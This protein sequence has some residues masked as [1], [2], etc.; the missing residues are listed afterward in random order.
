MRIYSQGLQFEIRGM[1][2][3]LAKLSGQSVTNAMAAELRELLPPHARTKQE[4][5]AIYGS[6]ILNFVQ[7]RV[8]TQLLGFF[9]TIDRAISSTANNERLK[10]SEKN[11]YLFVLQ[12]A[13]SH[14]EKVL[15][16]YW[17][18]MITES[19]HYP[20]FRK[21]IISDLNLMEGLDGTLLAYPDDVMLFE[22]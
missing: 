21:S 22:A 7:E 13:L 1:D 10:D 14:S 6:V 11:E 8:G 19:N 18:M 16:F 5:R 4:T 17:A 3:S 9:S 20:N 2:G 12:A 15:M